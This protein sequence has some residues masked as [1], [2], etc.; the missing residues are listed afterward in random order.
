MATQVVHINSFNRDSGTVGNFRVTFADGLIRSPTND[1]D[2]VLIEPILM[3]INRS[4]PSVSIPDNTFVLIKYNTSTMEAG[5]NTIT[6]DPGYYTTNP[7]SASN[8]I[9]YLNTLLACDFSVE[10]NPTSYRLKFNILDP[11]FGYQMVFNTWVCFMFGFEYNASVSFGGPGNPSYVISDLPIRMS[12]ESLLLVHTDLCLQPNNVVSNIIVS[13]N[14]NNNV[15]TTHSSDVFL[16][17]AL[18]GAAP[19]DTITWETTGGGSS[20]PFE[21]TNPDITHLNV[22]LT[23]EFGRSIEPAFD[24]TISFRIS[25]VSKNMNVSGIQQSVSTINDYLRYL[26]LSLAPPE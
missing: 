8:W 12:L 15:S 2:T 26:V 1:Y 5:V 24:Y 19:Y 18:N 16:A 7:G 13:N 6:I 25:Y 14:N 4:W 17:V 20:K 22:Y 10:F 3:T 21:L 9:I 23:D 11:K